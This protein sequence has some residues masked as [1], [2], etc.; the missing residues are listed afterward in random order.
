MRAS[1]VFVLVAACG[2]GGVKDIKDT[3]PPAPQATCHTAGAKLIELVV[4]GHTPPPPDDA[5]NKLID[6]VEKR[7]EADIWKQEARACFSTVKTVEDADACTKNL[8][9]TQ[10]R[11]L[12]GD[13]EPPGGAPAGGASDNA[14]GGEGGPATDDAGRS[15]GMVPKDEKARDKGAPGGGNGK[16]G[17]PCDGGE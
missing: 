7:C 9:D 16:T 11:N 13:M 2:G 1:W 10:L 8:T 4:A 5:V 3:P 6:Q 15:R 17:D 14:A 12:S